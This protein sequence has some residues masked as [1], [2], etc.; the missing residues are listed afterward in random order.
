MRIAGD[1]QVRGA[2]PGLGA[3]VLV[4]VAGIMRS[5]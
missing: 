1:P 4:A 5:T 2:Y 3:I